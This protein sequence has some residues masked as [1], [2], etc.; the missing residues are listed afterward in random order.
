M[1]KRP[2]P[3]VRE[4]CVCSVIRTLG[5]EPQG[6][7]PGQGLPMR[8]NCRWGSVAGGEF[9]EHSAQSDAHPRGA[10]L[11]LQ[12]GAGIEDELVALVCGQIVKPLHA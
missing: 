8:W 12:C 3:P 11:G 9:A 2:F 6:I 7:A 1:S 4:Q 10:P 5:V